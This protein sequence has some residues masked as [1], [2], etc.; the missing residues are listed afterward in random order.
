MTEE[1]VDHFKPAGEVLS[2]LRLV[3][4]DAGDLPYQAV[5]M[6]KYIGPD[7]STGWALRYTEDVDGVSLIGAMT[8]MLRRKVEEMDRG[9]Q[10][11]ADD[12]D[13]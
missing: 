4:L 8:V 2:P 5:V 11:D 9:W 13:D 7:G 1:V 10:G 12:D 6:V 3:P